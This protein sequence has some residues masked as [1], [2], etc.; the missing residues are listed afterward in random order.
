MLA[1]RRTALNFELAINATKSRWLG[2]QTSR[3]FQ[4]FVRLYRKYSEDQPRGHDGRWIDTGRDV[5]TTGSVT[6]IVNEAPTGNLEIDSITEKLLEK[7]ADVLDVAGPGSGPA[8]GTRVHALFADAVRNSGIPNLGVERSWLDA[9]E[10]S[11]YGLQNSIRTDVVLRGYDDSS[12]VKAIW[13]LKTGG[14]I[15]TEDRAARIRMHVGVDA[16]VPV[17]QLSDKQGV[18]LK[19]LFRYLGTSNAQI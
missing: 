12:G 19:S 2:I 4:R 17:I 5:E 6:P 9:N 1:A 18:R 16:T 11:Q 7:L 15:L 10:V 14:A 13:D 8:Y 3:A